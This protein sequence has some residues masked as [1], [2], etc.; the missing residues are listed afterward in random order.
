MIVRE[1][2]MR[3]EGGPLDIIKMFTVVWSFFLDCQKSLTP[4]GY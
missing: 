2:F 3:L 1:R 4:S